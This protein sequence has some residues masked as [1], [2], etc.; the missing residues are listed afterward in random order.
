M[1]RGLLWVALTVGLF[2]QP[3]LA[4]FTADFQTNT[5]SAVS[6]WVG[7]STYTVGSNTA[8]NAL[9]IVSPGVLSN[10]SGFVGYE[11][12]ASNNTVLVSGTGAR[13][14]NRF[15]IY[16]GI[17]SPG[18]RLIVSNQGTVFNRN[19][20]IGFNPTAL[21][22][23]V[24]IS[25]TGS[26]WRVRT[27]L[28]IGYFT[29]DNQ[30]SISNGAVVSDL[31][32]IIGFTNAPG[33][34]V[35]VGG[36][37]S[38][39]SNAV[40]L[41]V[42]YHNAGNE[43]IVTNG[44]TVHS[45]NG[46]IGADVGGSNNT[47]TVTGPGA[48]WRN[49]N[50]L[51]VGYLGSSNTLF[52]TGGG[53]VTD[54]AGYIGTNAVSTGNAV[55]VADSGS[56]WS[57][58]V[59]L[60]VGHRGA[61][62]QLIVSNGATVIAAAGLIGFTNTSV[63]NSAFIEGPGST[64]SNGVSL[65][66]GY[67][68]TENQLTIAN[69]ATVFSGAGFVGGG[70]IASNNTA[71]ITGSG[72]QWNT[73]NFLYV[74]FVGSS[75]Q[76]II[77]N[78]GRASAT[79]TRIGFDPVA[80]NN[81]ALVTGPD[82]VLSNSGNTIVGYGGF[83]NQ[84]I[85]SNGATVLDQIGNVGYTNQSSRNT[86][87]VTGFGSVWSNLVTTY[88]GFKSASNQLTIADGGMVFD[89]E[90]F[91]G[92]A[93][94]GSNNLAL[95]TGTDSYWENTANL[96]VGYL[97]TNNQLIAAD[98]GTVYAAAGIV[99]YTNLS[100][101]SSALV[102]GT[103][104]LWSNSLYTY[105][106]Y[107]SAF[108]Q[109][110]VSNGG[111]AFSGNAY[112]GA[113]NLAS[114]NTVSLVGTGSLWTITN[115][116]YIG[117]SGDANALVVRDGGVVTSRF[118]IVA[119]DPLSV[120]NSILIT[121]AGSVWSNQSTLTIGSQGR[122]N[123]LT[124][125]NGG[126][127]QSGVSYIGYNLSSSNNTALITGTGS[128]WNTIGVVLG[129][130]GRSNFLTIADGGRINGPGVIGSDFGSNNF[131]VVTGPGSV[132]QN[133]T[134]NFSTLYIGNGG[135]R[136]SLVISNGGVVLSVLSRH[137]Y[138]GFSGGH[139]NHVLVSDSGSLWS[140][141]TLVVGYAANANSLVVSNGGTVYD[142]TGEL[143][144][145]NFIGSFGSNNT[146]LVTG[147][148]S[149][150]ANTGSLTIGNQS[151]SNRLTVALA[152]QVTAANLFVGGSGGL[153]NRLILSNGLVEAGSLSIGIGNFLSGAG[154][155]AAPVLNSGTIDANLSGG[156]LTLLGAV[157]NTGNLRASA[158]GILEFFGPVL[159]LGTA[160]FT[161]GTAIFHGTFFSAQGTTNSW[162]FAGDGT[163]HQ[164]AR[165]SLGVTPSSSNAVVLITNATTKTITVDA[166][167]F[168]TAP[169]SVSNF[170]VTV[171]GPSTVTNTLT[172]ANTPA[173]FFAVSLNTLNNGSVRVS[174]ATLTVG[175]LAS[176]TLTA[177]GDFRIEA[178]GLLDAREAQVFTTTKGITVNDGAVLSAG[179]SLAGGTTTVTGA[180]ALWSNAAL[181]VSS[182]RLVISNGAQVLSTGGSAFTGFSSTGIVTGTGTVWRVD[183]GTLNLGLV[184]SG[185]HRLFITDG[186]VV[187]CLSANID[188]FEFD[189]QVTIAGN[190]ALWNVRGTLTI[191]LASSGNDAVNIS[192]GG[193]VSANAVQLGASGSHTNL[194]NLAGGTLYV[195]NATG[196]GQLNLASQFLLNTGTATIDDLNLV[197]SSGWVTF[198]AGTLNSKKTTVT[199]L[200]Q[201]VVGNGTNP[202]TYRLLG[203]VHSF[204]D[205]LLIRS[206][207]TLAGCGTVSANVTIAPG[208]AVHADCSPLVFTGTVTNNGT[209]RAVAGSVLEFYGTVVN[210]G[211]L[212]LITGTTNF[213][214]AFINNGTILTA[215]S[216][217]IAGTAAAGNDMVIQIPSAPGH[218]YQLQFTPTLTP[219]NWQDTG[220]AQPGTGGVLILTDSGGA[221]NAPARFYRVRVAP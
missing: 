62:N 153:G 34:R 80:S 50:S 95:V 75:N 57:N 183:G 25:D 76:L 215:N 79:E 27:N 170:S 159:N 220:G 124:I 85:V 192:T 36:G 47:A 149:L 166:S 167:T 123:R 77:A 107:N 6:N 100:P 98:G 13:W 180:S 101:R 190:N 87:L 63:R 120:S 207:A 156:T 216:V 137:G 91:I 134:N 151:H 150:W 64:W 145:A 184:S 189:D 164:A 15:D 205:G 177:S 144:F 197:T 176:G 175:L 196:N 182:S 18:N 140:N 160:N 174:N 142:T 49:T 58:T 209:L 2:S 208:G 30:V 65:Y 52:I 122:A 21:S 104:S 181:S 12:F 68:G 199:N 51:N 179:V 128:V 43:L 103:G 148:G 109:L 44:G 60:F 121:G 16:H 194:L 168:A 147:P 97:G 152:G 201:F 105:T 186:A 29:A 172:I 82:T 178:G 141:Q 165:W 19:T 154:T 118:G 48:W 136:N 93:V 212:D 213:H 61:E 20:Y 89:D 158:G 7:N 9:H 106:G 70:N 161:G 206:N 221:T 31:A 94:G 4:Q 185:G 102:T 54:V 3:V 119:Q 86:A 202:A 22:N 169:G 195:T 40:S 157:K 210:N 139:S 73:T 146:A 74:G 38:V 26:V 191:S 32:G 37:G 45:G 46:Y 55:I 111:T 96:Y 23:T 56:L 115:L 126:A 11:S 173:P 211:T 131:A 135:S 218:L 132:W 35:W 116:L 17:G 203:G 1:W 10:G 24:L 83:A 66:V 193:I 129:Y 155:L 33:N 130:A 138:G 71:T 67:Y 14:T 200:Q 219:P 125:T 127:L 78:G 92:G 143:G 59:N 108:N 42:G 113:F 114:N 5:I 39:W 84:L 72:A 90:G 214:G 88:V 28:F 163:W 198:N 110:I 187:D 8:F 41:F 69:G 133:G 81:F 112:I 204:N 162:N 53:R 188:V 171:S 117:F 99:G 217:V